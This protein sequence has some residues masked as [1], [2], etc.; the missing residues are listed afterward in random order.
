M[1]SAALWSYRLLLGLAA[2]SFAFN[3]LVAARIAPSSLVTLAGAL[4]FALFGKRLPWPF[5]RNALVHRTLAL[6][7]A[8]L[9]AWLLISNDVSGRKP[10]PL[11]LVGATVIT[12]TAPGAAIDDAAIVIDGAGRISAVGARDDVAVPGGPG[13]VGG[14]PVDESH[15]RAKLSLCVEAAEKI[16]G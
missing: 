1:T 16:W 15:Q 11:V 12:G 10:S 13:R 9:A 2:I 6:A 5:L 8:P 4:G 14:N 3:A 7:L